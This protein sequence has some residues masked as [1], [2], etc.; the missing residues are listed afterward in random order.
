ME[1]AFAH[2][3]AKI[4]WRMKGNGT[5]AREC[6]SAV[7]NQD[8]IYGQPESAADKRR[9]ED[10]DDLQHEY[11]GRAVGRLKRFFVQNAAGGGDEAAEDRKDFIRTLAWLLAND[12]AYALAYEQTFRLLE[13]AER[14]TARAIQKAE[15]AYERLMAKAVRL[16]DG[17]TI[18][19]DKNGEVRDERGTVIEP[20][21]AAGILW[22][23][24][25][26]TYQDY[27][28]A[29]QRIDDLRTYQVDV[30]GHARERLSDEKNPALMDEMEEINRDIQEGL[31]EVVNV[32]P[33]AARVEHGP[34]SA[35][36]DIGLPKLG[37]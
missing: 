19:M 7:K 34:Y 22:P 29:R 37:G 6:G 20:E 35:A 5:G 32:E 28:S 8:D 23:E 2:A 33:G 26:P 12:P 31:D 27:R 14:A 10:H 11:A 9:R 4:E 21:I 36:A 18:F 3:D 17:R 24:D 13:R 25:A 1:R 30:L 15:N 16:P